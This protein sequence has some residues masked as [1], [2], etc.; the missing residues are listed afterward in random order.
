MSDDKNIISNDLLSV[1]DAAIKSKEFKQRKVTMSYIF[2][3]YVKAQQRCF[4]RIIQSLLREKII[5]NN[6]FINEEGNCHVLY[7]GQNSGKLVIYNL[8]F[9]SMDSVILNGDIIH[10]KD[11]IKTKVETPSYLL[12]LI[13]NCFLINIAENVL[14][15]V[16]NEIDNSMINDVLCLSYHNKWSNDIANIG[17][18][19]IAR[20]KHSGLILLEQWGCM[21]HP[22]HPNYKTKSGLTVDDVI[23][24]SPEFNTKI[25]V[26]VCAVLKKVMHIECMDLNTNYISW[27]KNNFSEAWDEFNNE[28]KDKELKEED[29][30]SV[31]VHPWQ[32]ENEIA[33]LFEKEINEGVIVMM[34]TIPFM[35]YPGMSFRTVFP[36]KFSC[37]SLVKMP[38]SVRLTSAQRVVTARS[39][40]MGPRVSLFLQRILDNDKC[41]S[42][43]LKIVPERIGGHYISADDNL[44]Q[45]FS[46]IIRD[47]PYSLITEDELIIPVGS[48]FA[49]NDKGEPFISALISVKQSNNIKSTIEQFFKE[50]VTVVL[51]GVLSVY[52]KYGVA[53]EA[54]QQNS[55]VV[56]DE[57]KKIKSILI[58]DF[59]DIRINKK[60][61]DIYGADIKQYD[62]KMTF[63]NNV[64]FIR[65]KLI[66]NLFMCHLGELILLL[67]RYYRTEENSLWAILAEMTMR[68][69]KENQGNMEMSEWLTE[70]ESI[71]RKDWP[72]KS[73][74]RM[75]M[76]NTTSDIMMTIENPLKK[77]TRVQLC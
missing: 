61:V 12:N 39:A 18:P 71:L 34:K 54:H 60:Y 5:S 1:I 72:L 25:P 44:S 74:I 73:F 40:Q 2:N 51:Y 33:S 45:N 15:N 36:E 17:L 77:F 20:M 16:C 26:R 27:W 28:L 66:H 35:A 8:S 38:V 48:L 67:S 58:R 64:D 50:Y 52:L 22:W 56:F 70:K 6:V 9:H 30:I 4:Q 29:Y 75:R 49:E 69:F 19:E 14:T 41:L 76:K 53:F 55:F 65:E 31:M 24:L 3:S 32:F 68:C 62:N 42:E 10:I 47:N 46:F 59:G 43:Y 7:P 63:I 21:G 57:N 13:Q 23:S 11:N 37:N